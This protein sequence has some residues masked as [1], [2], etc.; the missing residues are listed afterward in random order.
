VSVEIHSANKKALESGS[1]S[2]P[3]QLRKARLKIGLT[4]DE[5]SKRSGICETHIRN[6][7]N[8]RWTL[9][10]LSFSRAIRLGKELDLSITKLRDL[11]LRDSG[12]KK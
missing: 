2:T 11:F 4:Q 3:D 8:G 10:Q 5:L 12:E 9:G 7:E 1:E 6:M